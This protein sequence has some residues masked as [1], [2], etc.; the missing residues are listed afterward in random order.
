MGLDKG[1]VFPRTKFILSNLT[2]RVYG[3]GSKLK[4]LL[5]HYSK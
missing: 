1:T 3:E 5:Y 2:D 4:E